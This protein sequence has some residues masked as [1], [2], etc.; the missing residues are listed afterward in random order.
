[1]SAPPTTPFLRIE[2]GQHTAMINR[3]DCDAGGRYVVT[4]SDD[5]T[6]RLWSA[7]SGELLKV[8]RPPI[9][10]G[11]EGKLFAVAMAPDAGLVAAAGW[12]GEAWEGTVS[13]YLFDRASG[14]LIHRLFGLPNVINHLVFSPDGCHLVATLGEG[15]VRGWRVGDWRRVLSDTD[16]GGA[17]YG[18]AF[19]C[20]GRLATSCEDGQLRLYGP[21]FRLQ[22]R[23]PAPGGG[24]PRGL[25]FAPDG[26]RLLVG[27]SD[28]PRLELL[29]GSEL[30]PLPAPALDGLDHG[31]L[32]AVAWS[33][34]G[35]FLFAGGRWQRRGDY[36]IRRWPSD[37]AGAPVDLPVGTNTLMALRPFGAAGVLWAA[38]DPAWGIVD[39]RGSRRVTAGPAT[40]DLRNNRAGFRCRADGGALRFSLENGARPVGFELAARRLELDPAEDAAL[41]PPR[42][43]AP[44]LTVTGWED[45]AEPKLNGRP[46]PLEQGE[47][48]RSL[49]LTPAGDRLVLGSDWALQLF[50]RGGRQLWR[51]P[52]PGAVW[53]VNVSG[54]GRLVVAAY[55]DGTVRWHRLEDGAER[56]AL[57][58][59]RDGQRWVAW[60]PAGY[61]MAGP[62][63]EEL[64]GWHLNNGP[65]QAADFFSAG[66]FRDTYHRPDVVERI[67]GTLDEAAALAQANAARP[68]APPPPL[69]DLAEHL[70]P[71][72]TILAP[73]DGDPVGEGETLVK[74]EIRSPSNAPLMAVRVLA[75]GRPLPSPHGTLSLKG[76]ALPVCETLR[77]PLPPAGVDLAVLATT[78]GGAIS[79]PALVRL[80]GRPMTEAERAAQ[81]R[82]PK[83]YALVVGISD[84]VDSRLRLG[85]AAKDA[86]D[87]AALLEGQRRGGLYREV[88]VRLLTDRAAKREALVDGLDWLRLESTANDVAVIFFAGHGVNDSYNRFAL[89]PA[90]V[91]ERRLASTTVPGFQVEE[92]MRTTPGRVVAFLDACH[93]GNVLGTGMR[94]MPDIDRLVNELASAENG[95]VVFAAATGRQVAVENAAWGNGAFTKALVEG[96]SGRAELGGDGAIRLNALNYYL[97][98]R[99]KELTSGRQSPNM[100][101]PDSIR[102]FPL[103]LVR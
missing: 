40:A 6:V 86:R 1:M 3:I 53:G 61:Y 60:T 57:F 18:A 75:D 54:D 33:A 80:R 59:H 42:T 76:R 2:A 12:T 30:T 78:A 49:A 70:P 29:S 15:G 84:Y 98:E 63:G 31:N 68:A 17:S 95:L 20:A 50:D 36:W 65:D 4:A 34:D 55:G 21:D 22:C 37:G 69:P 100:L 73:A 83:L 10:D 47:V 93:S 67:L 102:D 87:F 94:G 8:L 96:L 62:G 46:L 66:R 24:K 71:L 5:K 16:Y 81:E 44:G 74:I 90:D 32:S 11:D 39:D 9:G 19:D 56:L 28:R 45:G 13:V 99:V 14:K 85:L 41:I 27:Y 23:R 26:A 58:V 97:A 43:A 52:V 77:L 25:A 88:A 72:V 64:I 103:A 48:S 35:R 38:A 7:A 89:I 82:K 79:D 51:R 92:L 91:D 101:R